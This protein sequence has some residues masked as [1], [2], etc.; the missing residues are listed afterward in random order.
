M[1]TMKMSKD[2][3]T[4]AK[5]SFKSLVQGTFVRRDNRFRVQVQLDDGGRVAAHLANPGR[6]RELL[7]PGHAVWLRPAHAPQRRTNYDLVLVLYEGLYV[8]MNSQ[9]P[10]RLV[11]KALRQ[12]CLPDFAAYTEV[13]REIR[14]GESRLDFKLGGTGTPCWI[15]VKSVTLVV[16][17]IA[18]FPDAPTTRGRRHLHELANIIAGGDRGAVIFVVQRADAV[19]FAPNDETDPSFGEALRQARKAGVEVSALR[20][21]VT[22]QAIHLLDKV[23]VCL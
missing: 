16:N 1:L 13:Q 14:L 7:V 21:R 6:L 10:N 18:R 20:C 19:S 8:S 4:K 23:P 2:S 22:P 11:E 9:L 5:I 15:E 3:V 17:G 12:R